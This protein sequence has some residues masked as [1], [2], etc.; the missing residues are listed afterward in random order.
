M[1]INNKEIDVK[2]YRNDWALA[3]M[4]QG[5]IVSMTLNRWRGTATLKPEELGLKFQDETSRKFMNR[6]ITLGREKLM[7]P[8]VEAA[9]TAVERKARKNIQNH[10]F[11]TVWGWFVPFTAFDEWEEENE[12]IRK[13]FY[14]VANTVGEQYNNIVAVVKEAY[15]SMSQDVW[16]R[17]YP[18]KNDRAPES[19][20]ENFVNKIIDKIPPKIDIVTSFKYDVTYFVIP[21]PS[22][23]ENNLSKARQEER[24][25][26][27]DE[28]QVHLERSTKQKVADEYVKRK[29]ELIDGF[30]ESTVASMRKYVAELC[31]GV[32][33]SVAKQSVKKCISKTQ[34]DNIKKMINKVRTLNFYDDKEMSNLLMNLES[35]IGKFKGERDENGIVNTLH[36]IVEIGTEEFVPKDFNPAISAL[37]V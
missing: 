34:K 23:I 8:E 16:S 2:Q 1:Q 12:K 36:R 19:F 27:M 32:L 20:T 24:K 4:S 9:I 6:Y 7:P 33:Q 26:E 15:K 18:T 35:E 17:L 31:D 5:I 11:E 25:R 37:E 3:L 30:L 29:Q 10:S 28:F 22:I 21:M 13:E 14:D